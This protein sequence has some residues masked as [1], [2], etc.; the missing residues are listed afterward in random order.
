MAYGVPTNDD[1][2]IG[3]NFWS[4]ISFLMTILFFVLTVCICKLDCI[5]LLVFVYICCAFKLST[6]VVKQPPAKTGSGDLL[7]DKAV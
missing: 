3:D 1:A 6:T 4:E 7:A 5:C 2:L